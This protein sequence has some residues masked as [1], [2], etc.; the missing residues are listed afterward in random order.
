MSEPPIDAEALAAAL[1]GGV[2]GRRV[3]VV[4]SAGSTN[5]LA[6]AELG[7]GEPEGVCVIADAQTAGRGRFGRSWYS[8]PGVG[9]W[10]S[11]GLAP[12]VAPDRAPYLVP[13]GAL[14]VCDGVADLVRAGDL[15]AGVACGIRWPNDVMLAGRKLAGVIVESRDLD[16]LGGTGKR[17]FVVGVGVNANQEE[18]DFPPELAGTATSLRRAFGAPVSRVRLAAA[19]LQ[20]LDRHY[21]AFREARFEAIASAWRARSA[22]VGR[23]VRVTAAGAAHTG[24]VLD[25]DPCDGIVVLLDLGVQRWFRTEHVERLEVIDYT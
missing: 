19:I 3:V 15:R 17:G 4:A 13:L 8:P 14:A 22:I 2:V 10:M 1:R 20:A 6:W 11:V 16:G 24:R 23:R 9:L 18:A 12:T 5:D 25:L 21:Q 7:K